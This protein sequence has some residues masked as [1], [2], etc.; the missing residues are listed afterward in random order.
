MVN[1]HVQTSA[2]HVQRL[3]RRGSLVADAT[4]RASNEHLIPDW[5][6][7]LIPGIVLAIV[8]L[9]LL[10][11]G[12][13]A[14]KARAL[15]HG[16]CAQRPSHS[17]QLGN[18]YL[19]FDARMTGIYGG[20]AIASL[21][22][23]ARG[24][25]RA[26]R[27]PPWFIIALL[28]LFVALMAFDGFNALL[29][30]L[31]RPVFYQPDNRLRLLTGLLAGTALAVALCFLT[32]TTLWRRLDWNTPT[33]T[34][35][36]DL[37]AL[38][39]CQIPLAAIVLGGSSLAYAPVVL[40]LIGGAVGAVALLLLSSTLLILCRD[41]TIDHSRQLQKPIA[42]SLLGSFVVIALLAAG[43]YGLEQVAGIPP[44]T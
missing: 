24:R 34:G 31:G 10:S 7:W 18:S 40:V 28:V 43:R 21:Y 33:L 17:L 12:D 20:F 9:L 1:P 36:K 8:A 37:L 19:P 41:R 16:L 35:P 39:L 5:R 2:N 27:L 38:G 26:A 25:F 6:G 4:T 14:D 29:L 3:S 30:D 42:F 44:L 32:A 23:M 11:P 15:L 13:L 22:L